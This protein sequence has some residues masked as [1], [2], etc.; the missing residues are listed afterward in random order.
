M[1]KADDKLKCVDCSRL[2]FSSLH[3]HRAALGSIRPISIESYETEW[4][5]RGV[6]RSGR[7][8]I[9]LIFNLT[10]NLMKL[11]GLFPN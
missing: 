6:G 3:V 4:S 1:G 2:H 5:V 10:I 8:S 11:F 9:Y 7:K